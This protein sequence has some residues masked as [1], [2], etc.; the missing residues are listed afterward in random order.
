MD[1]RT[2]RTYG[3]HIIL[4][5]LIIRITIDEMMAAFRII[6]YFHKKNSTRIQAK[7]TPPRL[8]GGRVGVFGTRSPHRPAAIGLSLAK[9]DKI[10]GKTSLFVF[11]NK[12]TFSSFISLGNNL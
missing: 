10:E 11:L 9:I 4:K 1:L 2:F 8:G 6:F 7:V 3:M 12:N 5:Q